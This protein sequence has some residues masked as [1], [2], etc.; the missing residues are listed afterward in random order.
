[1]KGWSLFLFVLFV[2][3]SAKCGRSV[4]GRKNYKQYGCHDF[5]IKKGAF[6]KIFQEFNHNKTSIHQ[7]KF[8]CKIAFF[9]DFSLNLFQ[10]HTSNKQ[11]KASS[12]YNSL[13]KIALPI[14]PLQWSNIEKVTF[15]NNTIITIIKTNVCFQTI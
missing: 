8:F 15:K 7:N 14:H 13:V 3:W 11:N 6:E 5:W 1:M 4:G 2:K 9:Y 10:F 12:I